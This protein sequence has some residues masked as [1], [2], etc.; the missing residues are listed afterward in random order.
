MFL[1][2]SEKLQ[3]G[4]G[5]QLREAHSSQEINFLLL[6]ANAFGLRR[7]EMSISSGGQHRLVPLWRP[8]ASSPV[9]CPHAVAVQAP[10][11][12]LLQARN[13]VLLQEC[14]VQPGVS[15]PALSQAGFPIQKETPLMN[16]R[17]VQYY[18]SLLM[19]YVIEIM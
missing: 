6:G 19:D 1:V 16:K 5:F 15:K 9:S 10:Q 7:K 12:K 4:S 11:H 13:T 14:T 3:E 2:K 18:S 17:E 8:D